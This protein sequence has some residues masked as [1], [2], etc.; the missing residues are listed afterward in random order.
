MTNLHYLDPHPTGTPAVF[1]LHG[2]GANCSSWT[3]QFEPLIE[4]GLRPIAPDLPGFGSSPYAGGGWSFKQMAQEL[5]SLQAE[6]KTGPLFVIGL[7]MGGVVAQQFALDFPE[8][9]KRLI[10][11]STFC[12]LRP[13]NLS[14]WGYFLERLL[15]V[16][17]IGLKKQAGV[18]SRRVFPG[19]GQ[20]MLRKMAEEQIAAADPRAY[21]AAMRALGLFDAQQRLKKLHLPTLVITGADDSTV[22]PARQKLLAE[23]I[24]GARQITIPKAGHAVTIDQHAA[25]NQ[26]MLEFLIEN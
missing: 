6:L 7:S 13:E 23:S 19:A 11:V 18:V 22:S 3:L 10:L 21:R 4:A 1:L 17:T 25:F 16:H 8:L 5:A 24:K 15:L 14:Q 12:V 9:V 20:E 2:L 26:A